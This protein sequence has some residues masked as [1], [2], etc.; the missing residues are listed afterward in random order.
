MRQRRF[1][2]IALTTLLLLPA[3][4]SR[5]AAAQGAAAPAAVQSCLSN[6][7][8]T[9]VLVVIGG[10][11]Y[12]SVTQNGE[13]QYYP[14]EEG[15]YLEDPEGETEDWEERIW[16]RDRTEAARRCRQFAINNQVVYRD[17]EQIRGNAWRCKVRTYRS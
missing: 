2:A 10:V 1:G 14:S 13:T 16:A 3:L 6:A 17:V 15:E 12:W 11:T 8:C 5:K 4:P 9:A 7:Y